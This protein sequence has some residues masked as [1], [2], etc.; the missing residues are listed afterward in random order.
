MRF[1]SQIKVCE[2]GQILLGSIA[3]EYSHHIRPVSAFNG[4]VGKVSEIKEK[5]K[6]GGLWQGVRNRSYGI[7][8]SFSRV[9]F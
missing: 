2:N 3:F 9:E 1:F 5:T 8:G 4:E 7:S 6:Q